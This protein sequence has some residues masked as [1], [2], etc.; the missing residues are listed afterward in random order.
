MQRGCGF[1]THQTHTKHLSHG[2]GGIT[3]AE[4]C[5]LENTESGEE[6]VIHINTWRLVCL[7]D[8]LGFEV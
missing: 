6:N 1:F 2:S 5:L 8:T 4:I 3:E 7:R